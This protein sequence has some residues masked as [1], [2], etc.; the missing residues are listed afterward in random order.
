MENYLDKRNF[1]NWYC[2]YATPKEIE[3]AEQ[4][5]KNIIDRLINEY[6]YEI[7]KI[8]ITKCFYDS[9]SL[10]KGVIQELLPLDFI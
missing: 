10:P 2:K 7:E 4:S 3:K 1:L 5:N 8:N 9:L 6:S